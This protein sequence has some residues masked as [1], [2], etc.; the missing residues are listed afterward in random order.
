MDLGWVDSIF[1]RRGEISIRQ[2]T[3]RVTN[4]GEA[5]LRSMG[6]LMR[7]ALPAPVPLEPGP[8]ALSI[9]R[10]DPEG[11]SCIRGSRDGFSVA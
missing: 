10:F 4:K 3:C 2:P 7:V 6:I 5:Y 8:Q 11:P 9:A 1:R